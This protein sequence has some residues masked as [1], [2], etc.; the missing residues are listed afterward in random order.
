M[1]RF[2]YSVAALIIASSPSLAHADSYQFVFSGPGVSGS[3]QLT[4]GT[5]ADAKYPQALEIT[6][7]SGTFTDT[8]LG[9]VNATITGLQPINHATPE[10]TN[11]AAPIDFSRFAVASGLPAE[12]HGFVTFDN[13]L[14]PGPSG[15]PQTASDYPFH[16]GFVDIYGIL[17]DISGG[18][19][20]DFWSNGI[21]PH[22]TSVDYG[23]AVATS[24]SA[25]DY[26]SGVTATAPEPESLWLL[27]TG[28]AGIAFNR[29][30]SLFRS[31]RA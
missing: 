10:P 8:N 2:L 20:V 7:I 24:D 11:L 27:G 22:T 25:L 5:A 17:F 9:I 29:R 21:L 13:L 16:G 19:V 3:V 26:T 12:S 4:Y 14:Y 6:G 31:S 1:T 18:Q 30:R 23:V 15:S 28:L